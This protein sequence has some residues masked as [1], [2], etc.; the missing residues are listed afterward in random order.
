MLGVR[1][2][3]LLIGDLRQILAILAEI[4]LVLLTDN[5]ALGVKPMLMST[6]DC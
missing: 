6:L 2:P 1:R 4:V 5:R 3:P